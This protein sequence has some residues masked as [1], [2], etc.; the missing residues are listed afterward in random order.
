MYGGTQDNF[1]LGGPSRTIN[2]NGITNREWIVTL[3]GDG[4]QTR[5][6]PEDSH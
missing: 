3:G 4:F 6:D 1:T 5:V 2:Q